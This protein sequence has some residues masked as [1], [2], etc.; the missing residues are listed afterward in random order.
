M[1]RDQA[2]EFTGD[3]VVV[4]ERKLGLDPVLQC[5]EPQ[6]LEARDL[7][8]GERLVREVGERRAAPQ[9][10]RGIELLAGRSGLIGGERLAPPSHKPLEARDVEAL[11]IHAQLVAGRPGDDQAAGLASAA[12]VQRFAKPRHCHLERPDRLLAPVTGPELIDQPVARDDL[13]GM[14]QEHAEQCPLLGT[15]Q[16]NGPAA[17]DRLDRS[18]DVEVHRSSPAANLTRG[19]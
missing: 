8:L 18:E 14:Q 1:R 10:Q 13:V 15:A 19:R 5:T 12:S 16:R 17:F 3:L 4:P 9:S 6:L 7:G 2:L 11:R